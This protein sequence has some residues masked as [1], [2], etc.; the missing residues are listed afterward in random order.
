MTIV[1]LLGLSLL[2][3]IAAAIVAL[4]LVRVTGTRTAWLVIAAAVGLMALR[5]AVTLGAVLAGDATRL[6]P[7]AEV[8]AL[9]ISA[10]MLLGLALIGP[11]FAATRRAD[12]D[13]R[14]VNRALR[15]MGACNRALTRST[16]EAELL[17]D[18]CRI[19]VDIG[20]YHLAWVGS[21]EGRPRETARPVAHA[22][23]DDA[24]RRA[25]A[26]DWTE[27][28]HGAGAT[29]S[30]IRTGVPQRGRTVANGGRPVSVMA[31]PIAIEGTAVGAL[32]VGAV[33]PGAFGPAEERVL[34]ELAEDLAFGIQTFRVRAQ[35]E[36][37]ARALRVAEER[38]LM[39]VRHAPVV[40]WTLD[41]D[42]VFTL[43]EGRGLEGL[44]LRPGEIVGRSVFEVYA[45]NPQVLEDARRALAGEVVT[46]TATVDG[47]VYD[48]RYNP[49]RAPDGT[50]V[51]T[52][53]VAIDITERR[54][55]EQQLRQAQ[56][57]EEFG[58][59][60]GGIAHD[61][62]N[63]LSV[64]LLY[65]QSAVAAVDTGALPERT[66]LESIEEAARNA[67]AMITKLLG[68]SRQA[69]LALAPTDLGGV[70]RGLATLL[71]RTLPEHIEIV[72]AA[73][74]PV[75]TVTAD[76]AAVEQMLLNLATNARDAMPDGGTLRIG[77]DDVTVTGE[78]GAAP[79]PP[80]G[81]Y[82]C[83]SVADTGT[84]MDEA[85]RAQVFEPFFTTKPPGRGTGLGLAMV[86]SLTGQQRGF[87][88][89]VS[90][91]GRGTEVRLYFPCV[92]GA[93][94][95]PRP[96][97]ARRP[98]TGGTETILLVEDEPALRRSAMRVLRAHG[99]T[100]V[101]AEDGEA[102]L[103]CYG[104][105]RG[106]IDLVLS[107]LVMP[108]M[109]GQQLYHAL[110]DAFG[111]VP[112]VLASGYG[113]GETGPL[114]PGI[115][116]IQKPWGMTE[117]LTTVRQALDRCPPVRRTTAHYPARPS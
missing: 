40:L 58:Q 80:P 68:L 59:I 60:S 61:F 41:R 88:D 50:L 86:R 99:Y 98:I 31:L 1:L 70:V 107:D 85:T 114:D 37:A 5:R 6:D 82:V 23:G 111:P 48:L 19:L 96:R 106:E 47:S 3:Q 87:V 11:W 56:K 42:G 44:G 52:I 71:R 24:D 51:G 20:G 66:D 35:R 84:G 38:L 95:S 34:G 7:M 55:L 101:T 74:R 30:A 83:V 69:D 25:L 113:G 10:L 46:S 75:A 43:S 32:T 4:R 116:L 17:R 62:K 12:T 2:L 9:V 18:T 94:P 110:R 81:R 79:G 29:G 22:A 78:D 63:L 109:G 14:R 105:R 90:E 27:A 39:V 13:V 76:S 67:A 36:A 65:T 97:A 15:T 64:I 16:T 92:A 104:S 28:A 115:P 57:M 108:R 53:G 21:T 45:G 91:L 102:A 33:E 73:E 89:V 72:L 8:V 26:A 100:V 49:L 112:F 93:A 117:L 77:V 54:R 103:D